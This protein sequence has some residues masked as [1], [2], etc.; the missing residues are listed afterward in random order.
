[1]NESER[2]ELSEGLLHAIEA[3]RTGQHF[4]RMAARSTRDP[5]GREVFE[6]LADE[7]RAHEDFLAA[8]YRSLLESGSLAADAKLPEARDLAGENPIFSEKI[9]GRIQG[10][11]LEMSAL[12][13]GVQLELAAFQ[14]YREKAEKAPS[15]EAQAFYHELADWESGHYQ[16]LLRQQE[17]LKEDYW[18]RGGF[19]PF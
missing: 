18:D 5:K 2:K 8:H 7:E 13:V 11:H 1:M 4:Y 14:F 16:A 19:S 15:G 9:K 6:A 10:A 12:S 3:E 17:S